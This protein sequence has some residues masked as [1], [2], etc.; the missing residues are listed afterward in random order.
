MPTPLNDKSTSERRCAF[1]VIGTMRHYQVGRFRCRG[2]ISFGKGNRQVLRLKY[3]PK[4]GDFSRNPKGL[5]LTVHYHGATFAPVTGM[6]APIYNNSY[7][8][9]VLSLLLLTETNI[10]GLISHSLSI[11]FFN[12]H[13]RKISACHE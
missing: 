13:C 2:F 5:N 1:I 7:Q 11:T 3:N 12:I 6:T 8:F 9:N 10:R 4:G